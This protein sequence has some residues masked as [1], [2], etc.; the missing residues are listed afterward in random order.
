MSMMTCYVGARGIGKTYHM[1][2]V[3]K[4]DYSDRGAFVITNYETTFSDLVIKGKDEL[5]DTIREIREFREAGY[6]P[7]D[8]DPKYK[9]TKIVFGID[10]AHLVLNNNAWKEIAKEEA[11][12]STMAEGRKMKIDILLSTQ[13]VNKLIKDIRIFVDPYVFF[14]AW[15]PITYYKKIIT[16]SKMH[17]DR[18]MIDRELRYLIPWFKVEEC[19]LDAEQTSH[20]ERLVNTAYNAVSGWLSPAT[21]KLY[22]SNELVVHKTPTIDGG[23]ATY[24]FLEKIRK[25]NA[26]K[27]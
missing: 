1:T 20:K 3:L 18:V 6:F 2:K 5:L 19:T 13:S 7:I 25:L 24:N 22:N 27:K 15:I 17:P 4:R 10:E 21:Y 8:I 11:L 26:Q 12:L 14:Q 16:K 9:S 23:K